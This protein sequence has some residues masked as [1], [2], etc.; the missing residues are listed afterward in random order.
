MSSYLITQ[1]VQDL[2]KMYL[3]ALRI[4]QHGFCNMCKEEEI[5]YGAGKV[6]HSSVHS[7]V[8][9]GRRSR[10]ERESSVQQIIIF[11]PNGPVCLLHTLNVPVLSWVL[12]M[13]HVPG[14]CLSSVHYRF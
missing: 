11:S 2:L 1:M 14:V 5:I 3:R 7:Y 12:L 9:Q 6:L 8:L 10:G 13:F 4:N